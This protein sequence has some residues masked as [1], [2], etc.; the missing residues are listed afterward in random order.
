[1]SPYVAYQLFSTFALQKQSHQLIA[2]FTELVIS[3]S[4]FYFRNVC[5][6]F[7]ASET[8]RAQHC[9]NTYGCC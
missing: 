2:D 6:C 1:M 3:R 7:P 8:M 5:S 9:L 4:S